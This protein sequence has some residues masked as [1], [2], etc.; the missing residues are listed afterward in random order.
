[1]K[2]LKPIVILVLMALSTPFA[3]AQKVKIK[4]NIAY[5]DDKPY[6]KVSDC[7]MYKEDCSIS[8]LDGKVI[9]TIDK[10]PNQAK[11]GTYLQIVF[12]GLNTNIEL[13]TT[14]SRI[15]K[16]LYKNNAV[17]KEGNLIPENV[18]LIATKYTREYSLKEGD[19]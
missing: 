8:N 4:D 14:M 18:K 16:L 17:D 3:T 19:D 10:L 13:N 6:L 15:V 5:V 12:K 2:N 9:I 11:P 7:G 1:M